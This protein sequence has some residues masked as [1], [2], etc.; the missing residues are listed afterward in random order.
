MTPQEPTYQLIYRLEHLTGTGW[1]QIGE[2]TTSQA[3]ACEKVCQIR[4]SNPI[5][6]I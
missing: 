4:L 6:R 5:T 3:D 2:E 1:R